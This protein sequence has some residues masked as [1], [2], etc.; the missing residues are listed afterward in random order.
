MIGFAPS[1]GLPWSEGEEE[2]GGGGQGRAERMC[3]EE[4]GTEAMQGQ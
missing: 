2:G 4:P 1:P 3:Q